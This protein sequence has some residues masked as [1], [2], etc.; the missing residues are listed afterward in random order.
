MEVDV[1]IRL[2]PALPAVS[3]GHEND[4]GML[5][6]AWIAS[7]SFPG[8]PGIMVDWLLDPLPDP[9]RTILRSNGHKTTVGDEDEDDLPPN[10]D[11]VPSNTCEPLYYE[12]E[13]HN[14]RGTVSVYCHLLTYLSD[15]MH[16]MTVG[17][18]VNRWLACSSP[19]VPSLLISPS[20]P[21]VPSYACKQLYND[22]ESYARD[23]VLGNLH[24]FFSDVHLILV[25]RVNA[26]LA[27]TFAISSKLYVSRSHRAW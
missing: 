11:D 5:N 9:L 8:G 13:S 21:E 2:L 14:N 10:Q 22:Y 16:L 17:R 27:Y 3:R 26:P 24:P 6:D 15:F 19:P 18:V 1:H 7:R 4:P 23:T 20:A 25:G 12:Y